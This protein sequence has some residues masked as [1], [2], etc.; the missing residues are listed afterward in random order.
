MSRIADGPGGPRLAAPKVPY[1]WIVCRP[2]ALV[3]VVASPNALR[4]KQRQVVAG[5]G[6]HLPAAGG[7]DV[8]G[9][10][11]RP[12]GSMIEVHWLKTLS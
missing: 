12:S 5:V 8:G 2:S 4:P 11:C 1:A 7:W 9:N 6:E 10:P 3:I